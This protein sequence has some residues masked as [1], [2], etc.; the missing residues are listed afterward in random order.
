MPKDKLKQFD[1]KFQ[2]ERPITSSAIDPQ[3]CQL[4]ITDSNRPAAELLT[5]FLQLRQ[6][7]I[8][9]ATILAPPG[10]G[11]ITLEGDPGLGKSELVM[12]C[13]TAQGLTKKSLDAQD[14][15]ENQNYFYHLPAATNP[16]I[17][18]EILKK[19]FHEGVPVVV[20]EFNTSESLKDL[21]YRLLMGKGDSGEP[22]EKPGFMLIGTQNP[23]TMAGRAKTCTAMAHR[24]HYRVLPHYTTEE[25]Y[26]ILR[27]MG[28]QELRIKALVGQYNDKSRG[29]NTLCFR[30]VITRAV[31]DLKG[32]VP[33]QV[34]ESSVVA[35]EQVGNGA[36][37]QLEIPKKELLRAYANSFSFY[38][39]PESMRA[40]LANK[41]TESRFKNMND[42]QI[43]EYFKNSKGRSKS[44]LGSLSLV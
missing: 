39:L 31:E 10:L 41:V 23:M 15:P 11:G 9:S 13:L 4:T 5:E 35:S 34:N 32:T 22:P 38:P 44:V 24:M 28:L 21:Y 37:Q 30:D 16:K 6:H 20:D 8:H 33:P 12:A 36:A 1:E 19:A 29:N 2:K 3:N 7:Q 27:E 40:F 42:N 43:N 26:L 25:M 18:R 14:T 17:K